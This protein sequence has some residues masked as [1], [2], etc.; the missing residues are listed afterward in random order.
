[1]FAQIIPGPMLRYALLGDA[2]ASGTTGVL[3]LGGANFLTQF[4]GMPVMF[5]RAIGAFLVV[6]ALFV[7]LV[8]TRSAP[9]KGA[10]WAIIGANTLWVIK[11]VLV[12]LGGWLEPT[13][14]GTAFVIAQAVVVGAFA[15]AQFVGLRRSERPVP[16]LA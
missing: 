16:H 6:Y 1:M 9:A 2:V 11:S 10:V 5:M 4:L 14:L 7:A 13:L 12:L 3:L 15:E 8:G